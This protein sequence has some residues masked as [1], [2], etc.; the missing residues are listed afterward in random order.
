MQQQTQRQRHQVTTELHPQMHFSSPYRD[1]L[2]QSCTLSIAKKTKKPFHK[3]IH[4]HI[5]DILIPFTHSHHC[6]FLTAL[7][8]TNFKEQKKPHLLTV[9]PLQR[10]TSALQPVSLPT[11]HTA[12]HQQQYTQYTPT[13]HWT[14]VSHTAVHPPPPKPTHRTYRCTPN[15]NPN[16]SL[17]LI[18]TPNY[19]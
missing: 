17:A 15:L 10:L 3:H 12:T 16:P 7:C 8:R 14:V 19:I 6:L 11:S 9:F 5:S 18:L 4:T 13:T 2:E 1:K